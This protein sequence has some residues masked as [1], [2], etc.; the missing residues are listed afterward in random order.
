MTLATELSTALI[1]TP[2]TVFSARL[3]PHERRT[4]RG[5]MLAQ[6]VGL[7]AFLACLVLLGA[8]AAVR[9]HVSSTL[10]VAMGL[11][12]AV[13][14]VSGLREF[15]RRT[16]FADLRLVSAL[17]VD[18]AACAIQLLAIGLLLIL[19]HGLSTVRVYAAIGIA[20]GI[21]AIAWL[22]INRRAICVHLKTLRPAILDNWRFARWVVGSAAIWGGG[23]YVYPWFLTAFKGPAATGAWAA[24]SAVVAL[25]N[26]LLMG[27]GNYVGP[28]ISSDYARAGVAGLRRRTY[29]S[30]LN[31]C[32]ALLPVAAILVPTG[33]QV[34]GR[35]YGSEFSGYSPAVALLA[36]NLLASAAA[37]PFSRALFV[38]GGARADALV[39]LVAVGI[40]AAF[41]LE[42]VHLFGVTGAAAALTASTALTFAVRIALLERLTRRIGV[43]SAAATRAPDYAK[44]VGDF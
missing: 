11:T 7:S 44:A 19:T 8:A 6:Q 34:V 15:I 41:G 36:I 27:L 9:L 35:L 28:L 30:S 29:R 43:G 1:A 5:A 10:V 39:N 14:P 16:C 26:P 23:M 40:L 2:Y 37:F 20:S 17:R 21:S 25:G 13:I 32:G 42:A 38:L 12:A 24:C 4:Y 31:L 33:G 18:T 3:Q 22:V